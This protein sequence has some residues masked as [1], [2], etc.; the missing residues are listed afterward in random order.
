MSFAP[1]PNPKRI[2][3]PRQQPCP[4]AA[5]SNSFALANRDLEALYGEAIASD[6][7]HHLPDID[8]WLVTR[9][10]DIKTVLGDKTRF[11]PEIAL[12]PFQ[13]LTPE[14]IATLVA[15][16]VA[17][18]R[19]M[20]DN[21]APSHQRARRAVQMAFTPQRLNALA[22]VIEAMVDAAIDRFAHLGRVDLVAELAYELPALVLFR[23]MGIDDLH[24]RNVKRWADNRLLFTFGRLSPDEQRAAAEQLVDYWQ[25]CEALVASRTQAPQDDLPSALIAAADAQGTVLSQREVIDIVFGLLLAGHETTTNQTANTIAALLETPGAWGRLVADPARIPYAVEEGLRYRPSVIAWRRRVLVD[26]AFG[27][28]TIPAGSNLLLML[29]AANR[30]PALFDEPA[31]YDLDRANAKDHISFGYGAHFCLGAPLA[32]LEMKIILERLLHR[33][34]SLRLAPDADQTPIETIQFRGPK[35]LLVEWDPAPD[36]TRP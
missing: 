20:V 1:N 26:A 18:T 33:L 23:M 13:A 24:V 5:F 6:A 15:G 12:Q 25:F 17:P 28:R 16:G 11:S 30:D 27:E 2:D 34:P 9:H 36:V 10:S 8:Y 29:A 19:I 21:P 4:F 31:S 3:T 7:V 32:R 35:A 22:P 14:T